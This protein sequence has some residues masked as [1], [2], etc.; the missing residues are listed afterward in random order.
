[1]L[2]HWN[3]IKKEIEE[4]LDKKIHKFTI[5]TTVGYSKAKRRF[6]KGL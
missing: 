2:F 6:L 3:P 1:M 4:W 5:D